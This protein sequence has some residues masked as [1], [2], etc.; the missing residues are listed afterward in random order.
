MSC[1]E[2]F[3][4]GL[5]SSYFLEGVSGKL[6]ECLLSSYFLEGVSGKLILDHLVVDKG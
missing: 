4:E 1:K 5:L 6:I 2:L 3:P